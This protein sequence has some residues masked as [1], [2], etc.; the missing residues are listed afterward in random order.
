MR[1]RARTHTLTRTQTQHTHTR[2][3]VRITFEDRVVRS[4]VISDS[5]E[6]VWDDRHSVF[7]FMC[8]YP[9]QGRIELE[10]LLVYAYMHICVCM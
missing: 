9:A 4:R 7:E 6:P 8:G 1:A 3:T 2:H 10:V 5:R